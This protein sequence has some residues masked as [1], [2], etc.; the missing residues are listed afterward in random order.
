MTFKH[1]TLC[2]NLRTALRPALSKAMHLFP[3][4]SL[5]SL[6]FGPNFP[7]GKGLHTILLALLM[8]AQPG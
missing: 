3:T 8:L 5:C 4:R 7:L 2:F 6:P 1:A